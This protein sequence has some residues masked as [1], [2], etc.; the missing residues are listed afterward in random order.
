M[1]PGRSMLPV[2]ALRAHASHSVTFGAR[3]IETP[4]PVVHDR[5]P[6]ARTASSSATSSPSDTPVRAAVVT[7]SNGSTAS[8]S[9]SSDSASA[10]SAR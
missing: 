4:V 5:R 3:L 7:R 8:R 6:A 10:H 2:T 1:P 9:R